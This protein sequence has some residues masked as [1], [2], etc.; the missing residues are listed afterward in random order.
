MRLAPPVRACNAA[1]INRFLWMTCW[2]VETFSHFS[3]GDSMNSLISRTWSGA[4]KLTRGRFPCATFGGGEHTSSSL[5]P[6]AQTSL[7]RGGDSAGTCG[8]ERESNDVSP[9]FSI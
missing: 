8:E 4:A 7:S 9:A 6:G 5:I 2:N 3:S 1:R